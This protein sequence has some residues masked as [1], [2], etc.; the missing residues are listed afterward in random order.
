MKTKND[1]FVALDN[2]FRTDR[3][4]EKGLNAVS[5]ETYGRKSF[6]YV[7]SCKAMISRC[8]LELFLEARGFKVDEDYDLSS[9]VVKV[10]VKY[11]RD[12]SY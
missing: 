12:I 3:F 2:Y 10:Q 7:C 4:T 9:T 5:L 11:F 8:K 1:L 6:I